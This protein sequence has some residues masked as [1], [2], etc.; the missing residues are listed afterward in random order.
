MTL[1][2]QYFRM[3]IITSP[4]HRKWRRNVVKHS[5]KLRPGTAG[6]K[7]RSFRHQQI[8][9]LILKLCS[10]HISVKEH[11]HLTT[12]YTD[13]R[14]HSPLFKHNI[15]W[16]A[17]TFRYFL[18]YTAGFPASQGCGVEARVVRSRR[19]WGGVRVGF[20]TTLGVGVVFLSDSDC[21]IGS[22]FTS[23]S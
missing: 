9:K 16:E 7:Q 22:F 23:H 15:C 12:P 10:Q 4:C 18:N 21:P 1:V 13:Q 14:L 2:P 3:Q 5:E 17:H 11:A 8:K 20:L 6:L 19:F